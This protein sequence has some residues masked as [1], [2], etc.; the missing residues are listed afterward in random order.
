MIHN[1]TCLLIITVLLASLFLLNIAQ[2]QAQ[3]N[4]RLT[5][6]DTFELPMV[7]GTISFSVSGTYT[8]AT[9]ENDMWIF[10]NL[11]LNG[12]RFQGTLKFSAKNC[13]VTIHAFRSNVL[14]YTVEGTGEQIMQLELNSSRPTHHSEWSVINQNSVF[15]AEGKNWQL[16]A[17]NT[18]I[19]RD[20]L[21][22][23]TVR[24]YNY[25]YPVD[26][27]PFYLQHSIIILTGIAVAVT[28]T[29]TS[30]IKLKTMQRLR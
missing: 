9:L 30:V 5:T 2:T 7:N 17:D 21:G 20:L 11:A 8:A 28:I 4:T 22:T 6:Q 18:I 13:N 29:L 16:L 19:V 10:N 27:R 12:S 26:D 24:H 1:K 15:F 14:R 3:N 25:G 23:L